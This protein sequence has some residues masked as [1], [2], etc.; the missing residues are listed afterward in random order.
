MTSLRLFLC[1][2]HAYRNSSFIN[3]LFLLFNFS[4]VYYGTWTWNLINGKEKI[5]LF[6]MH[7][8]QWTIICM[9]SQKGNHDKNLSSMFS[10]FHCALVHLVWLLK[11]EEMFIIHSQTNWFNWLD[12]DL[13]WSDVFKHN[14]I[15]SEIWEKM[16]RGCKHR[17]K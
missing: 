11:R 14:R 15:S 5:S 13:L 16:R 17:Y 10:L 12:C 7:P 1:Y 3:G 2:I 8:K 4:L 6:R 9:T